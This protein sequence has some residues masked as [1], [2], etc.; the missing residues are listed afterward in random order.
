MDLVRT[1]ARQAVPVVMEV[2]VDIKR[3]LPVELLEWTLLLL[4]LRDLSVAVLVGRRWWGRRP[5]LADTLLPVQDKSPR[6]PLF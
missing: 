1:S 3:V 4:P 6:S 5:T 2:L